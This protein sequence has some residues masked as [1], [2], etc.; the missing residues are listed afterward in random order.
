MSKALRVFAVAGF[1]FLA[2]AGPVNAASPV[3]VTMIAET[4][5]VSS[6]WQ[7]AMVERFEATHPGITVDLVSVAGTGL[8]P[9]MQTMLA[10]GAPLDIGY[11]D[12]YLVVEWGMEGIL[13]DLTPFLAKEQRQYRDWYPVAFDLYRARG[14]LYGL[15]QDLQI[16]GI[17]YNKDHYE[18]AG[19]PYPRPNWTY[20]DLRTSAVRLSRREADGTYSRHGFKIPSS[21]NYMPAVWAFGGDFLD[22][23]ADPA[24]FIG[25]SSQTMNA[26]EYLADLVRVGAVQDQV[27]HKKYAVGASFQ[28][29]RVSMVLSNTLAMATGFLGITDFDWDV[30]PLP[31]GPAGRV[32]FINGL[33]WFLF[34]S[35]KC[36]AEAYELLRFLTST[37]ALDQRVRMTGLVPPSARVFQTTWMSEQTKPASRH[38]LLEDFDQARSPWPLH[39]DLFKVIDAEVQAVIWGEKA[40]ASALEQMENGLTAQL[41]SRR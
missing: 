40:A 32:P 39:N 26:L 28:Q 20:D 1:L 14:G 9:K 16:G 6:K 22:D 27:T 10:G 24:M 35:S 23:W 5:D 30:V 38:L 18:A 17:F 11:M 25:K 3:T 7:A 37:E 2:V 21:R 41:K 8:V 12:P 33:G 36:K 15:P 4:R 31:K 19:L 29:Q 13:D 34:S